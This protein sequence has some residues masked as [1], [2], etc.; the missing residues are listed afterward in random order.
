MIIKPQDL[1]NPSKHKQ[2]VIVLSLFIR[3][4]VVS[5]PEEWCLEKS[6]G[7]IKVT[8]KQIGTIHMKRT[9]DFMKIGPSLF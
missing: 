6:N 8:Q 7:R 4:L 2:Q 5:P 3:K 9:K 1:R